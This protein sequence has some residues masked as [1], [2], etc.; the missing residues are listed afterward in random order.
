M[1]LDSIM[2]ALAVVEATISGIRKAYSKA[3]PSLNAWPCFVN[4]PDTADI[5]RATNLR[6][7]THHIKVLLFV[8]KGAVLPE[9]EAELRPY[10]DSTLNAFDGHV[11]LGG[12][13]G[14]S[15]IT[16]Y[17]YGIL[18]YAGVPFLGI[19]F[20]LDVTEW[21]TVTYVA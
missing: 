7:P 12:T 19:S 3:P 8:L 15:R 5:E 11:T 13:A 21:T 16:G 17:K 18:E 4:F 14:N 1:S 10:L 6:K 9:A 20:D 2:A